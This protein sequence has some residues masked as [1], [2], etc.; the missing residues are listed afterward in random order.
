MT[1]ADFPLPAQQEHKETRRERKSS[2]DIPR[3]GLFTL[4]GP[5]AVH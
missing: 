5:A 2:T 4:V 3:I 1:A